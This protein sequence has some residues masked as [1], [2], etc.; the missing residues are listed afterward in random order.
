MPNRRDD[1]DRWRGLIHGVGQGVL[2]EHLQLG[3]RRRLF[4]QGLL[5]QLVQELTVGLNDGRTLELE[6]EVVKK[7]TMLAES[8]HAERCKKKHEQ[9]KVHP[10]FNG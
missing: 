1:I 5:V 6:T 4:G 10:W 2:E 9:K 3:A 8:V 7:K